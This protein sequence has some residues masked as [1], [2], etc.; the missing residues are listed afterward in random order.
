M[1]TPSTL[2]PPA[3]TSGAASTTL[4][5]GLDRSDSP[6][7]PLGLP[8][9]TMI[10]SRLLAKFWGV[11]TR[12]LTLSMLVVSAE[13][14][15]SAGALCWIWVDDPEPELPPEE[16]LFPPQP[17]ASN[18]TTARRAAERIQD[19]SMGGSSSV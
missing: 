5:S 17:A 14:N 10:W 9:A 13:A 15:T 8:L 19:R 2:S 6:L 1:S 18:A 3:V 7:M 12:S 16:E 11:P 4:R